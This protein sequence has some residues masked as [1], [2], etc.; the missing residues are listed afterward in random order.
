[1][2]TL[3][4]LQSLASSTL[5]VP[6]HQAELQNSGLTAD[7]IA[8][9]GHFSAD[10]N[11]SQQITGIP[12]A[13]LIFVYHNLQGQPFLRSDG[14]P[15]VRIK[16]DYPGGRPESAPKYLSPA[17]QGN[18]P[19]FSR[20]LDNWSKVAKSSKVDL[21]ETEGEK[22]ADALCSHGSAAIGY[23][24]VW[25]WLD[26]KPRHFELERPPAQLIEDDDYSSNNGLEASR[27]L[28]ELSEIEWRNRRVNLVWDSDWQ[29]KETVK[30]ALYHRA[31]CHRANGARP[32]LITLPNELN[33]SKNGIDDFIVRHGIEAYWVLK[34][35]SRP[36]LNIKGS[37]HQKKVV[38]NDTEPNVFHKA[39]M[40]W[41]VLKD[42][43]G[44]RPGVGWYEWREN[45][46]QWLTEDEVEAVLSR[47]MDAQD[48][49]ERSAGHV[50]SVLLELKRRVL[51]REWNPEGK[52]AFANGTLDLDSNTFTPAHDRLDRLT[53]VLPYAFNIEATCPRWQMFLAEATGND[54]AVID[55]LQAWFKYALLPLSKHTKSGIEKSLDLFGPK[56]TGKGTLLDILIA[57]V[58][59]ENVGP[60]SPE[61]FKTAQGLASLVDKKLAIDSDSSGFLENVG[62]YNKVVSNELVEVRKLYKDLITLRLGVKVVRA[63]NHFLAVPDG[64]DG[65]DRR[66]TVL[67]FNRVPNPALRDTELNEKLR[68]ELPGIFAWCWQLSLA[69]MKRRILWAGEIESVA[70]ASIER[71]E[72]NNPEYKFLGECFPEGN[73]SVKAGNLYKSYV[74]WCQSNGHRPKSQTKFGPAIQALGCIRSAKRGGCY[75]YTVPEM[76]CFNVAQHLGIARP[77]KEDTSMTEGLS[78]DT[79]Q[80]TSDPGIEPIGDTRRHLAEERENARLADLSAVEAAPSLEIS[81]SVPIS[82]LEEDSA[83]I[84]LPSKA[85][86][87]EEVS[88]EI[89]LLKKRLLACETLAEQQAVKTEIGEKAIVQVYRAMSASERDQIRRAAFQPGSEVRYVGKKKQVLC[90]NRRLYVVSLK[91]NTAEVKAPGWLITQEIPLKHLNLVVSPRLMSGEAHDLSRLAETAHGSTEPSRDAG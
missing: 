15:F 40:A 82:V 16:P 11:L 60:A 42:R 85:L 83:F 18:R 22:K 66:L 19:Y 24:G 10:A 70:Q 75:Y 27:P 64:S 81:S 30:A 78:R 20:I 84:H 34:L 72:A 14:K 87:R 23:A 44:F 17:E 33:G 86:Q 91:E 71:Y 73:I 55:L 48:W 39:L 36:A 88:P 1:M 68:A 4:N 74:D 58:G 56:G 76:A 43:L 9:A 80:D 7:Q 2:V 45:H 50:K 13:G 61:T 63:Y 69:E 51:V 49:Q 6:H 8:R 35:H 21:D 28:P 90:G 52:L 26:R 79:A 12:Q 31:L 3:P 53:S 89:S 65:L 5:L 32:Y 38:L 29:Q 47:F 54:Q 41:A 37:G 62:A 46:W 77:N 59:S 25:S 67:S 57:L